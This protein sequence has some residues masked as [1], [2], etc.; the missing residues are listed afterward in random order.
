MNIVFART[1][2]H[3]HHFPD[4][5]FGEITIEGTSSVKHC[6][7]SAATKK[8]PRNKEMGWEKKGGKSIAQK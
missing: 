1:V 8:S 3:G 6:T 4:L 2:I 5:P 7:T